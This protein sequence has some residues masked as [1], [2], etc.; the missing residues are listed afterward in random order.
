[1]RFNTY[2]NN[3]R[4]LEWGLNANQG[5]LFD[6]LNQAA[7]WSKEVIIDGV[8]Y[9]WV[10]RHKVVEELPL[11]YKTD[12]TVYRHFVELDK[13]GLIIY[14]KQGKHGDKDLIRLTAKGKT[15]NEFNSEID[16]ELGNKSEITR[17]QFRDNSEIDPT[18]NNINNNYTRDHSINTSEKI[19][20]GKKSAFSF[21]PDDEKTAHWIFGLLQKLKPNIRK[22][23][24]FADWANTVR[25]MRERDKRTHREICELF[26][27]ANSDPFWQTN[28]LSPAKLRE[29]WDKLELQRDRLAPPR[30]LTATELNAVPWNTPEGWSE[31]L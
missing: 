20:D 24:N 16:S 9:Y 25:L 30:K 4:C 1:M 6:L 7:S 22:P 3:Q 11:F 13:K 31:M 12:D 27:W 28:I 19:S 17:K 23:N 29:Q 5:A 14:L 15:W 21:S 18:D 2:I 26:R 10:S 8:V